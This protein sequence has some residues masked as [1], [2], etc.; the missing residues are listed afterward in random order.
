VQAWLGEW[1]TLVL[2]SGGRLVGAVRGRPAGD[3]WDI[4]RLMVAPD[5]QGRGIGRVLLEAIEAAAPA[6]V[7]TYV[8]FTGALSERNIRIYKKSGYRLLGPAPEAPG[9]VR[10][11]KRRH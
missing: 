4:G 9:A 2:R 7:S 10:L 3:D 5:L 8:L 11:V 6:E 1:T